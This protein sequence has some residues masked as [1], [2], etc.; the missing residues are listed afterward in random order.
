MGE[1][2]F[3]WAGSPYRRT[4]YYTSSMDK[5]NLDKGDEYHEL[6][7][8]YVVY[9]S[10]TD[11]W[12]AGKTIYPVNKFLGDTSIPYDDGSHIT[13]VNTEVNDGSEIAN[14]MQYFKTADPNDMRFGALSKRVRFLKKEKGGHEAVNDF[15]DTA[16]QYGRE[17]GIEEGKM[18]AKRYMA[19]KLFAKDNSVDDIAETLDAD[20]TQ[21]EEWLE[22]ARA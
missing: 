18:E 6:P 9:I 1:A 13:Y 10:E 12:K 4:R 11:I 21:V 15:F 16:W 5:N 2:H 20:V 17:E 14:L 19:K 22:L 3:K 8:V 7:D